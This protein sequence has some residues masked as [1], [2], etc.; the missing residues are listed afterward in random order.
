ME[1]DVQGFFLKIINSISLVLLWAMMVL[2]VG[3]YKHLL[4]PDKG[5]GYPQLL[6]YI[7]SISFLIWLIRKLII[8]WK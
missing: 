4:I 1:E 2:G 8:I 6:F 3:I 5:W 7:F